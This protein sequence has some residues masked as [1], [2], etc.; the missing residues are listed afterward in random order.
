[1]W[2]EK[3]KK[4][5]KRHMQKHYI[6]PVRGEAPSQPILTNFCTGGLW[7]NII[8][9][10]KFH[11]DQSGSLSSGVGWSQKIKS[12]VQLSPTAHCVPLIKKIIIAKN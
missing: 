6:S 1:V 11:L 9:C 7:G 2:A 12:L 10:A 3:R 8:N 4:R 5:K